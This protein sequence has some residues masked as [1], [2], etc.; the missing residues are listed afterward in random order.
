MVDYPIQTQE[1]GLGNSPLNCELMLCYRSRQEY[2]LPGTRR[3]EGATGFG[4]PTPLKRSMQIFRTTLFRICFTAQLILSFLH[5]HCNRGHSIK[6][7]L[8]MQSLHG[9]PLLYADQVRLYCQQAEKKIGKKPDEAYLYWITEPES[10]D[11]KDPVN[12]DLSLLEA[13][14]NRLDGIARKIINKEFPPMTKKTEDVYGICEF[15]ERC[16]N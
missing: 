11:A 3:I 9:C 6:R 2:Q 10:M 13:T 15:G 12:V 4:A 14:R 7:A 1:S 8:L 5:M 16:W